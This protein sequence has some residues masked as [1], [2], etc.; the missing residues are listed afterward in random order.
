MVACQRASEDRLSSWNLRW[1]KD[2]SAAT[3]RTQRRHLGNNSAIPCDAWP[4]GG[5]ETLVDPTNL[6]LGSNRVMG[7][8][9][10]VSAKILATDMVEEDRT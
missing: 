9:T 6:P 4:A 5:K 2:Q 10:A 8:S 3:P 7:T 1:M